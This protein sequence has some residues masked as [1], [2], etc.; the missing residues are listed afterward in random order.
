[1]LR[2][3]SLHVLNKGVTQAVSLE[4]DVPRRTVQRIWTD[5][6]CGGVEGVNSK[7]PKNCGRKRIAFDA[8]AIKEIPPSK[9]TALKDLANELHMAKTTL[10]RRPKEG[11][12]RRHTNA[13]KPTITEENKKA[14]VRYAL[15]M[16]DPQSLPHEPKFLDMYNTIYIDE[17]WFYR[18]K[19]T[20]KF[21]LA[22]DEE[23]PLRTTQSKHFIEKV[24][25]LAAVAR[26]RFD[27]EKNITF[28]GKIGI[29]PFVTEKPAERS[30][31][32]RPKGTMET[33]VLPT[34]RRL[35]VITW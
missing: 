10:F 14:R 27:A 7:K 33:K 28:D 19:G 32:N 21:Y 34:P 22:N 20:Q 25:F 16:L 8:N 9:R 35:V 24:M 3:T 11:R 12:F 5:G 6:P 15:S 23:D 2:R 4:F 30:S 29:F 18:T 26:P 1:M 13:I 31:V 17:K